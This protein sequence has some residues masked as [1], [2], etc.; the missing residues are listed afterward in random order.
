MILIRQYSGNRFTPT[1]VGNT[2]Q[3]YFD[4]GVPRFTPTCV[5]N[6]CPGRRLRY[7]STVHPHVCG[8][9]APE[10]QC[11]RCVPVHPHVCG[12]YPS[13][14][15]WVRYCD[16]SPP[17]V[18]GIRLLAGRLPRPRRFTPTCVGNTL[19]KSASEERHYG[20]PPRVWG[21]LLVQAWLAFQD[22]VHPHVCGEYH[23][24]AAFFG[25]P[26]R[27]TPTC[28]GNTIFVF[29]VMSPLC[30]SPPR[31]WGILLLGHG[32]CH[33]PRFTPTCVGNTP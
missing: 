32:M 16:G 19:S 27:F 11:G 3:E 25:I 1:C 8:E 4:E 9:Y 33:T 30:G 12:E 17:R 18:W 6:T 29:H 5:G 2:A 31:V 20:S 15:R 28:V 23:N 14:L 13:G 7:R 22:S 21:I 10:R 24:L 26:P